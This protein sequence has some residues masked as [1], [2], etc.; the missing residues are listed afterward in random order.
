MFKISK[1]VG[2]VV[3]VAALA[4]GGGVAYA[5]TVGGTGTASANT[6]TITALDITAATVGTPTAPAYPGH[7]APLALKYVNHN[8]FPVSVTDLS[9][10]A[11]DTTTE[12]CFGAAAFPVHLST[13][14]TVDPAT[15][16][17][18][19]FTSSTQSYDGAVTMKSNADN[20]CSTA[21]FLFTVTA[22]AV[23]A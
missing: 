9:V 23:S 11:G 22:T 12:G 7:A 4:I 14:F 3:A 17:S 15:S 5:W 13:P 2:A 10:V 16:T 18:A 20:S 21:T 19:A 6:A 8:L 1:R